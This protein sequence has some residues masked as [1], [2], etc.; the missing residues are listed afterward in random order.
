MAKIDIWP[1]YG[2][3]HETPGHPPHHLGRRLPGRGGG[4]GVRLAQQH[5]RRTQQPALNHP[6]LVPRAHVAVSGGS[7]LHRRPRHHRLLFAAVTP[8]RVGWP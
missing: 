4:L 3:R 1:H 6:P 8:P 7:G 5:E 2:S